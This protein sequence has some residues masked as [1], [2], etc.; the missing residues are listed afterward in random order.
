MP[1]SFLYFGFLRT[2]RSSLRFVRLPKTLYGPLRVAAAPTWQVE[3][4]RIHAGGR[5]AYEWTPPR[6]AKSLVCP[7]WRVSAIAP[8]PPVCMSCGESAV[9]QRR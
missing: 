4:A 6:S 2:D 5:Y 7:D 1:L 8:V 9:H 3:T